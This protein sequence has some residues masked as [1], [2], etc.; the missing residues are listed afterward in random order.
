MLDD[1]EQPSHCNTLVNLFITICH[2]YWKETKV[3]VKI[4]TI[5]DEFKFR[6]KNG[7]QGACVVKLHSYFSAN[8]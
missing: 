5:N 1:F 8:L 6:L 7:F 2:I 4:K 3:K